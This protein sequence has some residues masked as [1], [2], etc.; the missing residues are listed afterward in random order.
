MEEKRIQLSLNGL[1]QVEESLGADDMPASYGHTVKT[2]GFVC[3]A[4]PEFPD[5]GRF[6]TRDYNWNNI[7][8]NNTNPHGIQEPIDQEAI[9]D[10]IGKS[11][12]NRNYFWLKRTFTAPAA[13]EHAML[14]VRKAQFGSRIW[15]NSICV[16]ERM[17]C[18]TAGKYD[19]T[20]AIKWDDENEIVIR[21]G[22]HPGVL[23]KEI[24]V[25]QDFEKEYWQPGLWDDVELYAFD[26]PA[27]YF[28]QAGT[29][30]EPKQVIAEATLKNTD[31]ADAMVVLKQTVKAKDG[32]I[33]ACMEENVA[34]PAG[35]TAVSTITL[36]VP[37]AELWCPE[38]PVLYDL[39][40]ETAGD[41][42]VTR[43]GV[44]EFRFD[45]PTRSAY[46]NNKKIFLRGGLIAFGRLTEDSE[47]GDLPWDYDWVRKAIAGKPREMNWNTLKLCIH[48][49][50]DR[51]LQIADEEGILL[52]AEFPI[53][54]LT[55]KFFAGYTKPW[56]LPEYVKPEM[57]D[58]MLEH[59]NHPS[60]L[61]F[62]SCLETYAP[63]ITDIVNEIRKLDL[64]NHPWS[65]SWNTPAGPDDPVEDHQYEYS[66]T[67][68]PK[69]W[70][71]PNFKFQEFERKAACELQAHGEMPSSHPVVLTEYGWLFLG[72]DGEPSP[73]TRRVWNAI[74][75][76]GDYPAATADDR[77]RTHAYLHAGLT[78]YWRAFRHLAGIIQISYLAWN[79]SRKC[80]CGYM[81]DLKNLEFNPYFEEY[82]KD[83]FNPMG[84]YLNFWHPALKYGKDPNPY[85]VSY[86]DPDEQI[87]WTML[88]N[89]DHD[90]K[91]GELTITLE[92]EAG[93][94]ELARAPFEIAPV[95]QT[96]IRTDVKV[97][98]VS[99]KWTLKA[100]AV[101]PDGTTVVSQR[102]V[103]VKPR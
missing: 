98:H 94:I 12:Q 31:A 5:C 28:V 65:N 34:V 91:T 66:V 67:G 49:V 41:C 20:D 53:W 103:E 22:A 32:T 83:A 52:F 48:A 43:V 15:V 63:W 25:S 64:N 13:K 62:N 71:L 10:P 95:G 36:A 88:C 23:P 78:E 93:K 27:I 73:L 18:M 9:A 70:G 69:E 90:T 101:R 46:L 3:F 75:E 4:E 61:Y 8:I 74:A 19:L 54:I 7:V 86:G 102:W 97:P 29:R 47:C 11:Y 21:L 39:V 87:L 56:L 77:F 92:N 79:D 37:E 2:P 51:W 30:I 35:G 6:A 81:S 26:G 38:N 17:S 84:V 59:V 68:L 24:V 33:L 40:T 89:D 60:I 96:T 100:T 80:S 1:W 72:R 82:V 44:R 16:G 55:P 45:T 50:P 14:L 99:G 85:A 76:D 42:V 57:T 58:W